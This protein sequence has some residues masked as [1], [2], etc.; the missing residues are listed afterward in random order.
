[1]PLD[2]KPEGL[3]LLHSAPAHFDPMN[4]PSGTPRSLAAL[5][6][7]TQ[8][9]M[10]MMSHRGVEFVRARVD[11]ARGF[12]LE[13][14]GTKTVALL[15]VPDRGG[16]DVIL[17]AIGRVANTASLNL[18]ATGLSTP[19]DEMIQVDDSYW[20]GAPG[21]SSELSYAVVRPTDTSAVASTPTHCVPSHMHLHSSPV[22]FIP[23]R[24]QVYALGD[25][26]GRG[27]IEPTA[28]MDGIKL[29]MQLYFD[30]PPS[31]TIGEYDDLPTVLYSHPAIAR[32][33]LTSTAAIERYGEV[34]MNQIDQDVANLPFVFAA[35]S[36]PD[37]LFTCAH[38]SCCRRW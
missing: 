33:G 18:A 21:V 8:I 35:V 25:V 1:M 37:H 6:S 31:E 7:A 22:T 9:L 13:A 12:T 34:R 32:I 36:M 28:I 2:P 3:D 14:N 16:Y 29:A 23:S 30:A 4:R 27:N 11:P 19:P 5:L 38:I 24:S 10:D 15:G 17:C 26:T 20:T